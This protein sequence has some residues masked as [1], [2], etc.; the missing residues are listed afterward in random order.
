MRNCEKRALNDFQE[1]CGPGPPSGQ[2]KTGKLTRCMEVEVMYQIGD[3]ILYANMGVCEVVDILPQKLPGETQEQLYYTL[4]PL[5][6]ECVIRTPVNNQ[7][8]FMR[9]VISK[10]EAEKL[11]AMIP[12]IQAEPYHMKKAGQLADH[13]AQS[14]NTHDCVDLIELTMSLYAKKQEAEE[15]KK[16]FSVIDERYMKRAEELLFGELAVALEIPKDDVP[17]YIAG[18]VGTISND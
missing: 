15:Q 11:I 2:A 8:V 9:P 16:K 7:K 6:Q 4:S 12:Q 13:Y 3:L 5:Y 14:L 17:A 1:V 18:K 10:D